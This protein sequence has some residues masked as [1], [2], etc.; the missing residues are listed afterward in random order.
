M[1]HIPTSKA[2]PTSRLPPIANMTGRPSTIAGNYATARAMR[3]PLGRTGAANGN[4][5]PTTGVPSRSAMLD[6]TNNQTK[7]SDNSANE[8]VSSRVASNLHF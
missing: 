7:S 8:K 6:R 2:G 3:P 4:N 1:M 5:K